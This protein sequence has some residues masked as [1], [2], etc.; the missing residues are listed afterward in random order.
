MFQTVMT[1]TNSRKLFR[2]KQLFMGAFFKK[3]VNSQICCMKHFE[4]TVDTILNL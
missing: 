1:R 4:V 3:S 2:S